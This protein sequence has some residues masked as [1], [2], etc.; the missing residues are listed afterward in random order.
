MRDSMLP[1]MGELTKLATLCLIIR[2][3]PNSSSGW[4]MGKAPITGYI[5]FNTYRYMAYNMG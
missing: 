4:F 3:K 5:M 1:M 2:D